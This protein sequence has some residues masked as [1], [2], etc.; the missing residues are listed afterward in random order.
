[1]PGAHAVH[2]ASDSV[3]LPEGPYLPAGHGEPE[4]VTVPGLSVKVPGEH[5]LHA[6]FGVLWVIFASV[7]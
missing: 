6:G 3:V 5:G 2:V 7:T 4:Q 1:M